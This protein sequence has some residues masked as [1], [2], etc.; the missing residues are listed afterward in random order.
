MPSCVADPEQAF[1]ALDQELD[2]SF[3]TSL[4]VQWL[5]LHSPN[6]G[7]PDPIPGQGIRSH[8]PQLSLHASVKGPTCHN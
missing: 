6:A 7:G 5:K 8:M 4:V 3:G 2:V 1:I